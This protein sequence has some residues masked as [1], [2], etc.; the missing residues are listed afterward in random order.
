MTRH[1]SA[2]ANKSAKRLLNRLVDKA[3]CPQEYRTAMTKLGGQLGNAMLNVMGSSNQSAYL[4]ATAEDA[5][6]LAQGVLQTLE[7][8]LASVGFSCIWNERTSL[9]GLQSLDVAPI[10]KQYKEPV[11]TVDY[12][13]VVKSIIS[14]SC[15]V[16]TNLQNLIQSLQPREIFI[17]AP[18]IHARAEDSLRQV[19]SK[20]ISDKFHFFYFAEDDERSASGEVLP[21]IG[22]MVFERS[23][24][25]GQASRYVPDIVKERRRSILKRRKTKAS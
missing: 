7:P 4:V 14:D 18:V 9:Y 25:N 22:G 2:V 3:T 5:D 1:Y 20:E 17:A 8:H 19:F 6:F 15:V 13:I 24:L 16:R 11:G 12:L 10:L 21:G 23:G